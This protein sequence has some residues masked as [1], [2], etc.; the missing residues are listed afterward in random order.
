MVTI[1]PIEDIPRWAILAVLF[2]VGFFL[3]QKGVF[4]SIYALFGFSVPLGDIAVGG[5][6]L[7][8]GLGV[9]YQIQNLSS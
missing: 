9:L 8:V 2:G 3:V 7:A 6:L 4:P 1:G 5:I